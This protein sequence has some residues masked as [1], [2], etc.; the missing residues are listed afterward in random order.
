MKKIVIFKQKEV[1]GL[2]L[3]L[4]KIIKFKNSPSNLK[5]LPTMV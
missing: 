4:K 3:L 1:S 2:I 5:I